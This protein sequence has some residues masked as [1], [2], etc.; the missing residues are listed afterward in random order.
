MTHQ[1][2]QPEYFTARMT[3]DKDPNPGQILDTGNL[4]I[5]PQLAFNQ[6]IRIYGVEVAA[7]SEITNFQNQAEYADLVGG[8]QGS[9][10]LNIFVGSNQIPFQSINVSDLL[11]SKNQVI[12]FSSPIV[13]EMKQPLRIG[14]GLTEDVVFG[15]GLKKQVMLKVTLICER[16]LKEN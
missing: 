14:G 4:E 3:Y 1:N 16:H 13:V 8:L 2:P 7:F 10:T 12:Y 5:F 15:K 11:T 6:E 9:L